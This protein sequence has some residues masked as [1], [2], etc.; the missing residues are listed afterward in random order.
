MTHFSDWPIF[1][2]LYAIPAILLGVYYCFVM[3]RYSSN[4]R[5]LPAWNIPGD[6]VP[7]TKIS[8]IVPARN[9]AENI[10]ACIQSILQN[11]HLSLALI[12]LHALFYVSYLKPCVLHMIVFLLD[13]T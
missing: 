6:F 1:L 8:V 7:T 4:W 5:A 2:Q 11:N 12:F 3:W 13:Y 10:E 9:E